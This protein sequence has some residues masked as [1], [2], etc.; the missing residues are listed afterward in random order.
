MVESGGLGRTPSRTAF[1]WRGRAARSVR[2][3]LPPRQLAG[4]TAPVPLKWLSTNLALGWGGAEKMD[5]GDYGEGPSA[6]PRK[7]RGV[8]LDLTASPDARNESFLI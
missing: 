7:G 8:T 2:R 3:S 5:N 4:A 6:A 1:T